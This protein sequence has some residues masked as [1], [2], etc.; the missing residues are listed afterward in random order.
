MSLFPRIVTSNPSGLAQGP[1]SNVYFVD[2]NNGSDNNPGTARENPLE[3]ITAAIAKCNDDHGDVIFVT[4]PVHVEDWP[5][6]VNKRGVSIFGLPGDPLGQQPHTWFYPT[7]AGVSVFLLDASDVH[8]YNFMF[9][10][11]AGFPCIYF[12]EGGYPVR[13]G[14][15]NCHF[16]QGTYGIDTPAAVDSP[17][18]YLSITDCFFDPALTVGGIRLRSNGS[19][20]LIKGCFF[21]QVPGPQISIT[22]GMAGGRIL[23]N[24]FS[25]DSDTAGEAIT[26]GASPVRWVVD[27]NKA[28]DAGITAMV[29]NPFVDAGVDNIWLANY[30]CNAVLLPGG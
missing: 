16:T 20:P 10:G 1:K 28:N 26:L 9:W 12:S 22:G 18:H 6:T 2:Y 15:H 14:I 29:A 24:L 30:R 27:G 13:I 11:A 21:E 3:S 23:D 17:A 5:I 7:T 4:S 19:W 25:L 8:I